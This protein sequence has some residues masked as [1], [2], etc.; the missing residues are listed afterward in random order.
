MSWIHRNDVIA[1][2]E[3]LMNSK[4]LR[5]I[6]NLTSP[7]PVSNAEFTKQLGSALARP[8]VLSIP[9]FIVKLLFGEMGDRLLL[10]GQQVIPKRLLDNGFAFQYEH[11]NDALRASLR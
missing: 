11:L 8:T 1:A 2:I 4:V 9:G 7:R 5:G 10:H 3:Y 6:F